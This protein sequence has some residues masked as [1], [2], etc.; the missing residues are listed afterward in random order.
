[1]GRWSCPPL[2]AW[3]L[4]AALTSLILP[5]DATGIA[6]VVVAA[7]AGTNRAMPHPS[8]DGAYVC[9]QCARRG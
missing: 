9:N 7:A 5:S 2:G 4:G 1:M 8:G 3:G 6:V